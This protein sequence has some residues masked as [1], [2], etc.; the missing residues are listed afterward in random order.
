VGGANGRVLFPIVASIFIF[1]LAVNWQKLMPGIESVGAM[2]CAG[3][4]SPEIGITV[5]AGHPK[6]GDRLWVAEPLFAGYPADEDDYHACEEY[7][8]GHVPKPTDE[9]IAAIITRLD[10][11]DAELD[12]QLDSGEITSDEH[13]ALIDE[14]RLE[15]LEEIYPHVAVPISGDELDRGVVPYLFVVTPYVRG[16][17]TDLNLTIG[18]ALVAFVAIQVFGVMAQGVNYFQ[19]F[20]ALDALGKVGQRPL[21]LVDFLVGLFE[22]VSEFGK[23]VSLSFR[24]FGNLFAGGI[25]LAVMS[26]LVA[27]ILPGLFIG[28]EIIVTTIQAYVFAVLTL[29]FSAQAM[30]GHHGDDHD[31]HDADHGHAEAH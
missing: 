19:K 15:I 20:I 27:F 22:I 9:Q 7:K 11:S 8:E 13:S 29:V 2:H 28:L 4:S 14:R 18:L 30:E 1:L 16:G 25:L 5:G 24:L 12:A 3:H 26:F 21:G 6:L 23:I 17:S 31:D 10:E